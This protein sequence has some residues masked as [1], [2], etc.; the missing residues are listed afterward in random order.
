[1][2]LMRQR[3]V[4]NYEN[5]KKKKK[6][7]E[8]QRIII[9]WLFVINNHQ[10]QS[11][12]TINADWISLEIAT[13]RRIVLMANE[14]LNQTLSLIKKKNKFPILKTNSKNTDFSIVARFPD[15]LHK[16][17]IGQWTSFMRKTTDWWRDMAL[18]WADGRRFRFYW[19]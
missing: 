8:K 14:K 11:I 6:W 10:H 13:K 15:V 3:S 17:N 12:Q 5:W 16:N 7:E 2:W 9:N 1:M 19:K 4:T 18:K